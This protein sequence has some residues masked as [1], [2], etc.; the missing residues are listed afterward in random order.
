[1]TS[2]PGFEIQIGEL[3]GAIVISASG[4]LDS[5]TSEELLAA[6]RSAIADHDRVTLDLQGISFIDS[7]GMRTMIMIEQAALEA[8]VELEVLSP[9]DDVLALLRTAGVADRMSLTPTPGADWNEA[10]IE[11]IELEFPRESLSPSRA[12]AEVKEALAGKLSE[13]ELGQV[14]LLTSEL[15]TNAVIHP[16]V[17]EGMIVLQLT[18]YE[19]CIRIEVEDPGDGFD[20]TAP[21]AAAPVDAAPEGGRGLFLVDSC[22]SRW[23]AERVQTD[24]GPRFRV[25][26]EFAWA[27]DEPRRAS[28]G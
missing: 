15:M 9:A 26:F 27:D 11:Q 25:W 5:G 24:K 6:I 23:G 22:S 14:V 19:H 16:K 18:I 8:E 2:P 20:P 3:E 7:A 17:P 10:F 13:D 12:R 28:A 21:I 4:E 1:M